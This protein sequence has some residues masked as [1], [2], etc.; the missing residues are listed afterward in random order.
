[1]SYYDELVDLLE[2]AWSKSAYRYR[3]SQASIRVGRNVIRKYAPLE[4]F[5]PN[6]GQLKL[7]AMIEAVYK[8]WLKQFAKNLH[9]TGTYKELAKQ[10]ERMNT[11]ARGLVISDELLSGRAVGRGVKCE[12]VDRNVHGVLEAH[13]IIEERWLKHPAF[14]RLRKAFASTD[15]MP[16]IALPQ[17]DHRGN[18][19]QIAGL[20]GESVPDLGKTDRKSITTVLLKSIVVEGKVP[21]GATPRLIVTATTTEEQLL[22]ALHDIYKQ[23]DPDLYEQV[24]KKQLLD[25]AKEIKKHQ[26]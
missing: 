21:T 1:V 11:A 26:P 4:P 3:N 25:A 22:D 8:S 24:L 13:H 12:V 16:A 9:R 18:A 20:V 2:K 23:H 15:D 14:K 17:A 6:S 19:S 7:I 10:L 5:K